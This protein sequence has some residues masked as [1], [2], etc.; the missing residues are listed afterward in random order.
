[1]PAR[2]GAPG[3]LRC[4][5][6]ALDPRRAALLHGVPQAGRGAGRVHRERRAADRAA[7]PPRRADLRG[8]AHRRGPVRRRAPGPYP[9][10][11]RWCAR[12]GRHAGRDESRTPAAH[13]AGVPL[14]DA[15]D[16]HPDLAGRRDR[17]TG[18]PRKVAV[19]GAG[20]I[21]CGWAAL[22]AAAGW[23]VTPFDAS[24]RGMGQ[25]RCL[26]G[27]PLNPPQLIPL[28]ELGPGA[29]TAVAS[30]TRAQEYLRAL[31]RMPIVLKKP[32]PGYVVGRIA[33]AVWRECIDLV[34]TDVIA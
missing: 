22:F 8:A 30:V 9:G 29:R 12:T 26:V 17:L 32:V 25:G 6:R 15:R 2:G 24:S 7:A 23:P 10:E 31:G 11:A 34:L 1:R 16:A 5:Q 3:A 19:I 28:V 33:A 21:G 18:L 14:G 4:D 13:R 20:D 27:H